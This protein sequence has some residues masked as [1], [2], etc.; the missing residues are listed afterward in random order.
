MGKIVTRVSL[1]S[2]SLYR[3]YEDLGFKGSKLPADFE[4]T[5]VLRLKEARG[6]P[7]PIQSVT[8]RVL[9]SDRERGL[10]RVRVHCPLCHKL[11]PFGR[12]PAHYTS[13]RCDSDAKA[14][15][16]R[17][18]LPDEQAEVWTAGKFDG[19]YVVALFT[20]YGFHATAYKLDGSVIGRVS[21]ALAD[22]SHFSMFYLNALAFGDWFAEL[23]NPPPM[24]HLRPER[25]SFWK[26]VFLGYAVSLRIVDF[27][28]V[29]RLSGNQSSHVKFAK[30]PD[31]TPKAEMKE[32]RAM[33]RDSL[34]NWKRE[35][36]EMIE[37][38]FDWLL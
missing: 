37:T 19:G 20:G 1:P 4:C 38:Y 33:R 5:R 7:L 9:A 14:Y 28:T 12:F 17:V 32:Y 8:V 24:G 35:H 3:L 22:D 6:E 21:A 16:S 34:K 26:R 15:A 31:D 13:K 29:E 2:V 27:D 25:F 30:L 18:E 36:K 10:H 23:E 11:I